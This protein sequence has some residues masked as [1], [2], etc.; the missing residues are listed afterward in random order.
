MNRNSLQIVILL[1]FFLHKVERRFLFFCLNHERR[2]SRALTRPQPNL[3]MRGRGLQVGRGPSRLP[4]LT[5]R[6]R[7]FTTGPWWRLWGSIGRRLW[8]ARLTCCSPCCF[9]SDSCSHWFTRRH[10]AP[11]C[12]RRSLCNMRRLC[13]RK[14]FQEIIILIIAQ[15]LSGKSQTNCDGWQP[16]SGRI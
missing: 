6:P 12:I 1:L 4:D 16:S 14:T 10:S 7:V 15:I 8:T 2:F 9:I 11:L 13:R 5:H 3:H